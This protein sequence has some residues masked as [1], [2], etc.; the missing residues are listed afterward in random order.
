MITETGW[1]PGKWKG[2]AV[3]KGWGTEEDRFHSHS[4]A[5]S[6][7]SCLPVAYGS[8]KR[9]HERVQGPQPP[10]LQIASNATKGRRSC[11]VGQ[12]PKCCSLMQCNLYSGLESVYSC[13][14]P[15]AG[16]WWLGLGPN[17][18]ALQTK[19]TDFPPNPWKAQ[20]VTKYLKWVPT[21][22]KVTNRVKTIPPKRLKNSSENFF[23]PKSCWGRI[24]PKPN[25]NP[26]PNFK[27]PL[28]MSFGVSK[29]AKPRKNFSRTSTFFLKS[30]W[31]E[32]A[33]SGPTHTHLKG[34]GGG[35]GVA[36]CHHGLWDPDYISMFV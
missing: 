15:Y 35:V 18:K 23:P 29:K 34:R 12:A 8:G 21:L 11:E 22:K 20:M 9:R 33:Q 6:L 3:R 30:W 36:S 19:N 14:G 17:P 5:G 13:R 27:M 16:W 10:A 4:A 31:A 2:L 25:R 1:A 28:K 26:V 32:W 24:W 7:I